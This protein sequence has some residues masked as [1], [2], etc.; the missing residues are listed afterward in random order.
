MEGKQGLCCGEANPNQG[1]GG[2]S[3]LTQN[4]QSASTRPTTDTGHQDWRGARSAYPC[5]E[6]HCLYSNIPRSDTNA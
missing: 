1:L 3:G 4:R 2:N 6:N 5:R